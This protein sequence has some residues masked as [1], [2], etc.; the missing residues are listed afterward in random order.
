M[1]EAL[2]WGCR[3]RVAQDMARPAAYAG[4]RAH[5]IDFVESWSDAGGEENV[6]PC[7]LVRSSETPFRITLYLRLHRPPD[8]SGEHH[9]QA[10]VSKEKWQLFRDRPFPW[11]VRISPEAIFLLPE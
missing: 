9:L 8:S 6:F 3:L 2:D 11:H 10:E 1:V 7:W 5:H 4:I